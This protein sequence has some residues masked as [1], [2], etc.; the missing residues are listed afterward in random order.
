MLSSLPND[1]KREIVSYLFDTFNYCKND[2]FE[3]NV[4]KIIKRLKL[5][6][7]YPD[8]KI[9]AL[10]QSIKQL[11]NIQL[12]LKPDFSN[13]KKMYND[14]LFNHLI[15]YQ[16]ERADIFIGDCK[17][18]IRNLKKVFNAECSNLLQVTIPYQIEAIN[19][20]MLNTK[21]DIND[22]QNKLDRFK[23]EKKYWLKISGYHSN[24]TLTKYNI[25]RDRDCVY[26]KYAIENKKTETIK[27]YQQFRIT[28]EWEQRE[29]DGDWRFLTGDAL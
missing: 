27:M 24:G 5:I 16:I 3:I 23:G 6:K 19:K 25:M 9:V 11:T 8:G 28:N 13:D 14:L 21:K 7:D 4:F 2:K 18:E 12:I 20:E 17:N 26:V 10:K 1:L 15:C 22:E 29:S